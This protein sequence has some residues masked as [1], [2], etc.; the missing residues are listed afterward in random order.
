MA[1]ETVL[2]GFGGVPI[3]LNDQI[4][5]TRVQMRFPKSRKRRIRKKWRRNPANYKTI[6]K[7]KVIQVARGLHMHPET[8]TKLK[9]ALTGRPNAPFLRRL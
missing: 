1:G 8:F 3:Y 4:G 5:V 9:K 2:T 6:V 7:P